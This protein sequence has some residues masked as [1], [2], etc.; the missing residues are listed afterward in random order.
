MNTDTCCNLRSKSSGMKTTTPV[1]TGQKNRVGKAK[2][3]TEIS[4]S[5]GLW[6]GTTYFEA[7]V[8]PKA[9]ASGWSSNNLEIKIED[10]A[11]RKLHTGLCGS[12]SI[13]LAI[14]EQHC[15]ATTWQYF[16]QTE[17]KSTKFNVTHLFRYRATKHNL[18]GVLTQ[19]LSQAQLWKWPSP[20][21]LAALTLL[22][23]WYFL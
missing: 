6:D 2:L 19:V 23:K 1:R 3:T 7:F 22:V 5:L 4:A 17:C 12:I 15:R 8:L 16:S 9:S 18:S 21:T 13:L 14:T 20:S 10:F 11:P